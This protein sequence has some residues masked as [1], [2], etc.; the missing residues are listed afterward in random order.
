[1]EDYSI[2]QGQTILEVLFVLLSVF[3]A[4]YVYFSCRARAHGTNVADV[5]PAVAHMKMLC[6]VI[7]QGKQNSSALS[8][9]R[10]LWKKYKSPIGDWLAPILV[11]CAV[12]GTTLAIAGFLLSEN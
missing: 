3:I 4:S 8:L 7:P 1:M 6:Q 9:L 10:A 12:V 5:K 2:I 11:W